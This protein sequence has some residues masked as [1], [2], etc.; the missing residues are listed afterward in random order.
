M[1]HY[2]R[3]TRET[4]YNGGPM[5]N[6]VL[7]EDQIWLD[8][9]LTPPNL[10]QNLITWAVQSVVPRRGVTNR[11]IGSDQYRVGGTI[12][13]LL[14]HSQAPFWKKAVFEPT[15]DNTTLLADLPSYTI[16]QA[17]YNAKGGKWTNRFTGVKFQSAVITGTNEGTRA[18][19]SMSVQLTGSARAEVPA[20][21]AFA[22]PSCDD[23][24]SDVYRFKNSTL[25]IGGVS[26]DPII[27]SWTLSIQHDLATRNNKGETIND[28]LHT[29]WKP[30]LQCVWNIDSWDYR[31]KYL[32]LLES[33]DAA[34]YATSSL[35]LKD[36]PG[37]GHTLFN[38]Y[39]LVIGTLTDNLPVNNF[40]TQNATLIP[41]FDCTNMDMTVTHTKTATVQT[42]SGI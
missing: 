36:T 35:E 32:S 20:S 3:I 5:Q 23:L 12:N 19:V 10:T 28:I 6:P 39:N 14:F 41:N 24:P 21:P 16:D 7:N 30:N 1:R 34:K 29:G 8:Y 17:I 25:T 42:G 27:N 15:V 40:P 22:P 33:F 9:G 11:K 2:V 26:L 13:T 38:F 18:P 37:N 4:T 31:T